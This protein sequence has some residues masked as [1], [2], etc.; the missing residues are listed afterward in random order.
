MV[1]DATSI[2]DRMADATKQTI[3]NVGGRVMNSLKKGV[4]IL[5]GENGAAKKVIK[6]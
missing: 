3:Y 4:N 2:M 6:K 1:G 5:R